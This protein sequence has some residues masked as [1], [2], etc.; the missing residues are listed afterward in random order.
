MKVIQNHF[1]VV[2]SA[3]IRSLLT[4]MLLAAV[5]HE[6]SASYGGAH[7]RSNSTIARIL[8][9]ERIARRRLVPETMRFRVQSSEGKFGVWYRETPGK[10]IGQKRRG[11]AKNGEIVEGS[12]EI[13]MVKNGCT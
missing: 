3:N 4:L 10:L 11:M 1:N 13:I 9:A 5:F 12:T 7:R 8:R 2:S 6:V